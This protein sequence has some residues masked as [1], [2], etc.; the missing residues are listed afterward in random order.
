MATSESSQSIGTT[1]EGSSSLNR[2]VSKAGGIAGRSPSRQDERRFSREFSPFQEEI[3]DDDA[4]MQ[5]IAQMLHRGSEAAKLPP[6][7][8]K[9]KATPGT[10]IF[11]GKGDR[12]VSGPRV[13]K[14]TQPQSAGGRFDIEKPQGF[15]SAPL[16]EKETSDSPFFNDARRASEDGDFPSHTTDRPD[17]NQEDSSD[18][19]LIGNI[20][21]DSA[22]GPGSGLPDKDRAPVGVPQEKPTGVNFRDFG[23]PSEPTAEHSSFSSHRDPRYRDEKSQTKTANPPFRSDQPVSRPPDLMEPQPRAV[24]KGGLE[25]LTPGRSARQPSMSSAIEEDENGEPTVAQDFSGIVRLTEA[26][27]LVGSDLV[28]RGSQG[29]NLGSNS[30][31]GPTGMRLAQQQRQIAKNSSD[32]RDSVRSFIQQQAHTVNLSDP[33]AHTSSSPAPNETEQAK[34]LE[35]AGLGR[36]EGLGIKV[37]QGE[38]QEGQDW[39]ASEAS[40]SVKDSSEVVTASGEGRDSIDDNGTPIVTFRF[41]HAH[42]NDGHHVVVGREGKLQRCEDEPITTPGAVQGFG[43]LMVLEEDYDTGLLIVRQVSEVSTVGGC[44]LIIS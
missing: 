38:G 14:P 20:Q 11:T 10:A 6:N 29:S 1:N 30:A 4:G 35:L 34:S 42:T 15:F 39:G 9:E 32:T 3:E 21:N 22:E 26:G 12:N 13:R 24:G 8:K 25:G 41:E 31:S 18:T 43:V 5:T 16:V 23:G 17:M 44:A 33:N 28:G 2:A 19:V 37:G 40:V 7:P 27:S 36:D